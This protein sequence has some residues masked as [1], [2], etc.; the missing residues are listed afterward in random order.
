V[1][2]LVVPL[3]DKSVSAS[4][5]GCHVSYWYSRE[6]PGPLEDQ[7]TVIEL[8]S[9]MELP[10]IVRGKHSWGYDRGRFV[11]LIVP[12]RARLL[13]NTHTW[14]LPCTRRYD[15]STGRVTPG[16]IRALLEVLRARHTQLYFGTI[17]A[18]T[19]VV[20]S[21]IHCNGYHCW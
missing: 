9:R 17:K 13:R 21:I 4:A 7:G 18:V 2:C 19:G 15:P 14:A 10:I 5:S 11:G 6:C 12:R 16:Q 1:H 8:H 3:E 20:G